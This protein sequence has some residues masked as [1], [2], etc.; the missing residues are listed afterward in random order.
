MKKVTV[1][2][3]ARDVIQITADHGSYIEGRCAAC[4][5][6]GWIEHK[7]GLPYPSKDRFKTFLIHKKLCP[8]NALI[9]V[10]KGEESCAK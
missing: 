9:S 1:T 8:M 6:F 10:R 2:V 7:Y 4:G 3:S 5:A